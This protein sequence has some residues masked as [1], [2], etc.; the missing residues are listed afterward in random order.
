MV[1]NTSSFVT[2]TVNEVNDWLVHPVVHAI[3]QPFSGIAD[4]ANGVISGASSFAHGVLV[5]GA[6]LTAGWLV[7][8][9]VGAAFPDEERA[10]VNELKRITKRPRLF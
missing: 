7:W 6:W 10:I 4:K 9:A 5:A 2:G 1:H 3:E 8:S